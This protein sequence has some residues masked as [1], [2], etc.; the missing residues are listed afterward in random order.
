MHMTDLAPVLSATS[1]RDCIWIMAVPNLS[2]R[3]PCGTAAGQ[4][5]ARW[6]CTALARCARWVG[7]KSRAGRTNS[8][9]LAKLRIMPCR[10]ARR[11]R[12]A[13]FFGLAQQRVGVAHLEFARRLDVE[14]PDDAILDQ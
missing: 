13:Q 14:R 5:W 3:A 9:R 11:Q 2:R 8:A 6:P 10:P 4:S 7:L 1:S 12:S